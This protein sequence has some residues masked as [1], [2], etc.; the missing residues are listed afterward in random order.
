MK[1]RAKIKPHMVGGMAGIVTGEKELD[2]F[3]DELES[4]AEDEVI[5]GGPATEKQTR[6]SR[7]KEQDSVVAIQK[8]EVPDIIRTVLDSPD[9]A[10]LLSFAR[11]LS[12]GIA[13]LGLMNI[14]LD[15][16]TIKC[17]IGWR[18]WQLADVGKREDLL[19]V[20]TRPGGMPIDPKVGSQ[21]WIS[22]DEEPKKLW[23]TC[24]SVQPMFHAGVDLLC[25]MPDNLAME[26]HGKI[27]DESVSVV[28]GKPSTTVDDNEPVARGERV[29]VKTQDAIN[30][31]EKAGSFD[32]IRE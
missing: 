13:G 26:K 31:L 4:G 14:H 24:L 3:A 7:N 30:V 9:R 1:T 18:N 19:F 29:K 22:F 25:F 27:T 16:G 6:A 15:I 32:N 12:T 8:P 11:V 5:I 10:E 20:K 23:V 17:K 21:F 28:S 2:D